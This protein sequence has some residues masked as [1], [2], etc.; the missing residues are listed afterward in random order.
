MNRKR[1]KNY[2]RQA[3]KKEIRDIFIAKGFKG[4]DLERA[5]EIITSNKTVWIDTMLKD[6][7]GV[8][9]DENDHPYRHGIITFFSFVIAG[10][11]PLLPYFIPSLENA[12]NWSIFSTFASLYIIG[13]LR[14]KLSDEK[15]WVAGFEMML[16]GGIAAVIAYSIGAFLSKFI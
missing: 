12:F 8:I 13:A 15:W 1:R 5:V 3:E 14:Y 9:D 7:L 4:N 16:V 11:L 2:E 6:E 10:V